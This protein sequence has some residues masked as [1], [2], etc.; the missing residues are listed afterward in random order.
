MS[1]WNIAPIGPAPALQPAGTAQKQTAP[2]QDGFGEWLAKSLSQV[3]H[4]EQESDQSAQDLITGKS[5]DI[6][7]AMIAMQKADIALNLTMEIRN[8]IIAAY[9][10]I[11]R[12]QF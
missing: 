12:M 4:L 9:D 3:N 7:T 6:H 11:R 10:E 1:D 2:T 5:T 8:K